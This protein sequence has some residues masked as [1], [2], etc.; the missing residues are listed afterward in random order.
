MPNKVIHVNDDVHAIVKRHC[1]NRNVN[2][3]R[4]VRLI[5]LDA[6]ERNII[7]PDKKIIEKVGPLLPPQRI[8]VQV[9]NPYTLPPFWAGK[10]EPTNS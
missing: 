1:T 5:L 6:V 8:E 4:W 10:D 3:S 9:E 2:M 7:S